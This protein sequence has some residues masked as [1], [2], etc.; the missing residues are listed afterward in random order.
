MRLMSNNVNIG[1]TISLD[2]ECEIVKVVAHTKFTMTKPFSIPREWTKIFTIHQYYLKNNWY[3][4]IVIIPA[5]HV[6]KVADLWSRGCTGWI[7]QIR[8]AVR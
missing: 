2:T 5:S 1:Y 4:G 6:Q 8:L 3:I 7:H